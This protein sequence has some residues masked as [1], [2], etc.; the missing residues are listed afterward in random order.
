M[1]ARRLSKNNPSGKTANRQSRDSHTPGVIHLL[2]S[3]LK[4][5]ASLSYV[6]VLSAC[7]ENNTSLPDIV[8]QITL[9]SFEP[10]TVVQF[11]DSIKI[12]IAY[13]DGDGD[14]GYW[15]ADSLPLAV[16]DLRLMRPDYFYVRPLTPD[17]QALSISGTIDIT[18][19][20]TFLL[21]NGSYET[22]RFEIKLKDRAGHWSNTVVTPQVL[23]IR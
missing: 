22:T 21:G 12:V 4:V 11:V 20:N 2:V 13:E 10:D 18:I 23:I 15:N 17:S 8:P 7:S 16:H 1:L 9:Q 19:R 5:L 3:A 6:C 14:I